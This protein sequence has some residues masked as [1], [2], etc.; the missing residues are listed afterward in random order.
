M[1]AKN[2]CITTRGKQNSNHLFQ[3]TGFPSFFKI[4]KAI[5]FEGDPIGV[6]FPP[7]FAPKMIPQLRDFTGIPIIPEIFFIT[8][9]NVIVIGMLSTKPDDIAQ[10]Q[11][12]RT[13]AKSGLKLRRFARA[14]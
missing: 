6:R 10:T 9:I 4:P 2:S 5:M 11:I 12:F 13:E 3:P 14:V 1:L 7:R 8:G